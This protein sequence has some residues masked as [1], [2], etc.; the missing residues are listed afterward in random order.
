MTVRSVLACNIPIKQL[1]NQDSEPTIPHKLETGTKPSIIKL[2]CFI[3][4]CVVQNTT[5]HF[6]TKAVNVR[7][8]SHKC[9]P[10]IFIG[11]PQHQH[12]YLLYVPS[13]GKLVYSYDIIF[14]KTFTVR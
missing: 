12:G 1:V 7:H 8:Q 5:A 11:I 2:T 13:T 4:P 3:F 9:F 14:D 6:K 10:G